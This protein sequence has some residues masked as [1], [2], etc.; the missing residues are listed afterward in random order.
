[1]SAP[2]QRTPRSVTD[3]FART[4]QVISNSSNVLRRRNQGLDAPV[5]Q[6][7]GKQ[8]L[9]VTIQQGD[10]SSMTG[11]SNIT[12]PDRNNTRANT[13][14]EHGVMDADSSLLSHLAT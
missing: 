8:G 13:T 1:M 4:Q 2:T 9:G 14:Q 7:D 12:T 10:A 11:T 5:Q 6:G 3:V